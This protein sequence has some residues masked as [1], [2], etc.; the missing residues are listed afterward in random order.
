[1]IRRPA[2][3]RLTV[4][5][6]TGVMDR[7]DYLLRALPTWLAL[8]EVDRVYVVDWGS[9]PPL[10]E[11][12]EERHDDA[13]LVVA[14]VEAR[15]WHHSRCHNLELYLARYHDLVLR[16]DADVLVRPDFFAGRDWPPGFFWTVDW[17][18]VPEGDD[19]RNVAGTLLADPALVR[20]SGG[21]CER[22]DGYGSE[23]D[24]LYDRMSRHA[25]R[26]DLDPSSLE[27][28]P[29]GDDLRY[30]R[31]AVAPRL[32]GLMSTLGTDEAVLAGLRGPTERDLLCSMAEREVLDHPWTQADQPS[33]WKATSSKLTSRYYECRRLDDEH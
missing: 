5:V 17:R 24:E 4:A 20:L 14:R 31:L 19:R 13:R 7:T 22:L 1:M 2:E 9:D 6:T 26:L 29:H 8:G 11:Q 10:R 28:L 21:Y 15:A 12:L 30:R 27:H 3:G 25:T 23:D 16:I 32:P 33:R 18:K